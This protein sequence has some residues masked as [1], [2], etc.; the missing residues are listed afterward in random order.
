MR[1]VQAM[2][3]DQAASGLT[4][5][6]GLRCT[7]LADLVGEPALEPALTRALGKGFAKARS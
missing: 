2:R 7:S 4:F 1:Q 5:P 3:Q 6:I